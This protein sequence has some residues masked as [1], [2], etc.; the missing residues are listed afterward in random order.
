MLGLGLML[1][2]GLR[3]HARGVLGRLGVRLRGRHGLQRMVAHA[4]GHLLVAVA[5]VPM[6]L[7]EP[8]KAAWQWRK[9]D[10]DEAENGAGKA[11]M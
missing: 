4:V 10:A 6:R 5:A 1:S 2:L 3:G 9:A 7:L 11:I 8:V